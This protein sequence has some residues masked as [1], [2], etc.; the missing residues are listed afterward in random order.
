MSLFLNVK[1]V[2]APKGTAMIVQAV[3][4]AFMLVGWSNDPDCARTL[5]RTEALAAGFNSFVANEARDRM[6]FFDSDP[7]GV[8]TESDWLRTRAEDAAELESSAHLLIQ[9]L[10]ECAADAALA[11]RLEAIVQ[12]T[13]AIGHASVSRA[14]RL[15]MF[16]AGRGR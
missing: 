14:R 2:E 12:E 3:A 15:D 16:S 6:L 8:A 9:E 4:A 7:D 5:R 11:T 10:K 1:V 13:S